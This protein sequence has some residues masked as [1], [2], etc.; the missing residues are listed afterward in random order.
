MPRTGCAARRAVR[1]LT[2]RARIGAPLR[3]RRPTARQP[4]TTQARA[5]VTQRLSPR[6]PSRRRPPGAPSAKWLTC[7]TCGNRTPEQVNLAHASRRSTRGPPDQTPRGESRFSRSAA[8][9]SRGARS[10]G[11]RP[12]SRPDRT[13]TN[14]RLPPAGPAVLCRCTTRS[15]RSN[16]VPEMWSYGDSNPR[17]LACHHRAG[18]PPGSVPAGHR[19]GA[20]TAARAGPGRLR[21]F[22]AVRRAPSLT[23]LP[24]GCAC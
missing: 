2:R 5:R 16:Q 22:P 12:A 6:P 9:R 20:C 4:Q 23:L 11:R 21:Y 18:H 8:R 14:V 3:A 17:P 15:T 10:S 7:C 13:R 19:P 24:A 1:S